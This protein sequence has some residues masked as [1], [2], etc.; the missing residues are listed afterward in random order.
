LLF[1]KSNIKDIFS[2]VRWGVAGNI[3]A[4]RVLT[5]PVCGLLGYFFSWLLNMIF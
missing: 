5:F 4:A 2:S 3:V 1:E